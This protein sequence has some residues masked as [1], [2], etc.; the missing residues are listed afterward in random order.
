LYLR[1]IAF[2]CAFLALV[3]LGVWSRGS[4]LQSIFGQRWRSVGQVFRDLG[5]GLALWFVAMVAVSILGGHNGP[6]DAAIA[7]FLPQ[8]QIE[9]TLWM[10]VSTLAGI[11]EEAIYRGYLQKQFR[12]VN[13]QPACRNIDF[14]SRIWRGAW[15]SRM[16]ASRG[17][18]NFRDSFWRG[19]ALA[20]DGAAGN[21]C[22]RLAGCD[23]AAAAE[24]AAALSTPRQLS[25][26]P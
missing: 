18:R 19:G 15:V 3:T 21:V 17:D 12:C 11:S 5:S 20:P 22:T 7:F 10:V 13:R 1:T 8:T 26:S 9:M 14:G 24:I 2:E 16:V 25:K 4:S 23:R 6:P